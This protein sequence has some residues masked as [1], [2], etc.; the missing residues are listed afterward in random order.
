MQM[1]HSLVITIFFCV[2]ILI[3]VV[4]PRPELVRPGPMVGSPPANSGGVATSVIRISPH[5]THH[6]Q[7][8]II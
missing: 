3:F 8:T 4:I 5:T 2:F 6:Y 1:V 7:V